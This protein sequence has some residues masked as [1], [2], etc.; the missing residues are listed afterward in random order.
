LNSVT[1]DP[2][3]CGRATISFGFY[4]NFFPF[5]PD[6]GIAMGFQLKKKTFDQFCQGLVTTA[7]EVKGLFN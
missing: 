6:A 2:L 1:S 7:R 4:S 3:F 5:S